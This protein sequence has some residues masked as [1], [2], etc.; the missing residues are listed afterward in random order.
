[1]RE[2][3]K[4]AKGNHHPVTKFK[5]G[6]KVKLERGLNVLKPMKCKL[7]QKLQCAILTMP[8]DFIEEWSFSE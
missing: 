4:L 8:Q 5:K 1:M 7:N 2:A 3:A 6:S